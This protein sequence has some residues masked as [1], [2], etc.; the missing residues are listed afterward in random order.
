MQAGSEK[1]KMYLGRGGI[2]LFLLLRGGNQRKMHQNSS[3]E[4][5]IHNDNQ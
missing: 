2:N 3:K 5:A 4:R 1:L